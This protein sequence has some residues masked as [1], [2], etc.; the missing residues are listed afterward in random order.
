MKEKLITLDLSD[1]TALRKILPCSALKT[2]DRN[3]WNKF[4]LEH[5]KQPSGET[6]PHLTRQHMI[7]VY[8]GNETVCL[9]RVINGKTQTEYLSTGQTCIIPAGVEH[10]VSWNNELEFVILSFENSFFTNVVRDLINP[11]KVEITPLFST[12][13]PFIKQIGL[14]LKAE[15]EADDSNDTFYAQSLFCSL[16]AHLLRHYCTKKTSEMKNNGGLSQKQLKQVLEYMH[17]HLTE[18][19]KLKNIAAILNLSQCYFVNLFKQ[20]MGVP[21]YNYLIQQRIEQAKVL[22]E[23]TKLP[24]SQIGLQVGFRSPSRFTSSFGKYAGVTPKQYRKLQ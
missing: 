13:E 10:Q 20:S 4:Y 3:K 2:S 1:E 12:S 22:L 21:P 23:T 11:D 18:D 24:I 14:Q 9:E 15:L 6:P 19:L 17:E 7:G 8:L 16:A 5:H